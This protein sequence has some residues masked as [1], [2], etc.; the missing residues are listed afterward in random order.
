[1][2]PERVLITGAAGFL[3]T[4]TARACRVVWPDAAITRSDIML[5]APGVDLVRDL[6]DRHA[7]SD[8]IRGAQP[9]VLLHMAGVTTGSDWRT[10]WSA[11]V[12]PLA[13]VLDAVIEA[14]P[15]CRVLVPG[16]AAEYGE[17]D[18]SDGPITEAHELFP[19]SPYGVSKAWQSILARSYAGRGVE[20]VVGRIFNLAGPGVPSHFVLGAVADQLRAIASGRLPTVVR[21]GE[22]SAV[23]DFLDVDD[24]CAALLSLALHGRPGEVY[25][26]CAGTPHVVGDVV[27]EFVE[28]SGTG[29][30]IESEAAT[31]DRG[32]VSWSVGSNAK[33]LA[34]TDWRPRVALADSLRAMLA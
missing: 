22:L 20:V 12:L 27:R 31:S 28:L 11:N 4:A 16:S 34:E 32:N 23:R 10:L 13:N 19:H 8:L 18:P 33:L 17:A 15:D 14:A 6:S 5:G 29:A 1:V 25:N 30:T 2:N 3:G 9:D 26:V 7:T 24:A 21:I